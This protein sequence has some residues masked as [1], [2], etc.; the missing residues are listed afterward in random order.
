M[1]NEADDAGKQRG[2][3]PAERRGANGSRPHR[4][5][6]ELQEARYGPCLWR[7]RR[8]QR[9]HPTE[10]G[11]RAE[12]QGSHRNV[13]PETNKNAKANERR[14]QDSRNK[15]SVTCAE[16]KSEKQKEK[17]KARGGRKRKMSDR[18]CKELMHMSHLW[19]SNAMYIKTSKK[20]RGRFSVNNSTVYTPV[21][22]MPHI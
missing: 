12:G 20:A 9:A 3:A 10:D 19:C 4:R 22:F 2:R 21:Y 1:T 14:E 11:S 5:P 18:D 17:S 16:K 13:T 6:M 15:A 8:R 7:P